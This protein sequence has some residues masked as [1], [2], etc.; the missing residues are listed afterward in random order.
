MAGRPKGVPNKPKRALLI[1]LQQR[2]PDYHPV[3]AMA[4]IANDLTNDVALRAQMHTQIA[5]YVEPVLQ[6]VAI[7]HDT[8]AG[9][10]QVTVRIVPHA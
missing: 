5:R 7:G 1:A 8:E 9:P 6:A 4:D 3:L 10:L 2:H